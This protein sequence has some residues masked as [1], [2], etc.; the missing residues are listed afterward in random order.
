MIL[1]D[2]LSIHAKSRLSSSAWERNPGFRLDHR[3]P[4]NYLLILA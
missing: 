1:N 4:G 2:S 3:L